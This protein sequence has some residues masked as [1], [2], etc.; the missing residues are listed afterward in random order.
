MI[1]ITNRSVLGRLFKLNSAILPQFNPSKTMA[2]QSDKRFKV[3][4]TSPE[5]PKAAIDLLKK[6]CDVTIC[7]TLPPERS[8]MLKKVPGVDGVLW[9]TYDKLNDE[10]L[11]TAGETLKVISTMSSGIDYVDQPALKRRKVQLGHTP[12]V[13]NE[14]VAELTIA[15]MVAAA[16]RFHEG[17]LHIENETWITWSH[18][19]ML[20]YDIK[21]STVGIVGFGGIGQSIAQRLQGYEIKELLYTGRNEKPEAKK[22]NAKYVSF[23]ELLKTSD[24][25][26]AACPLTPET[27]EMF[28][29]AAFNKMKPTSIFVN[30]A[31]GQIADQ[32]AL[33]NALKNHTIF[34]AGLDVMTPEPLPKDDPLMTLPN[35]VI[36]P[37]LGTATE[38]ATENMAL[39]AAHNVLRGLAG[40]PMISPAY[41]L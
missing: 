10:V 2:S 7:E 26:I 35:C 6:S 23:D 21:G 25:V 27:K 34:A 3:L 15:L 38:K 32:K 8:E 14:P 40:E 41:Q 24:F 11:D 31:R 33:Y 29:E 30:V 36:I 1:S 18:K 22:Y 9:G 28:N 4:V 16:R 37:H 39:V 12:V 19:W 17:R 20:G 5:V 13:V